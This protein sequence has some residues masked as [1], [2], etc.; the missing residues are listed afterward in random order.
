MR[1]VLSYP[2]YTYD[3]RDSGASDKGLE[4]GVMTIVHI[5]MYSIFSVDLQTAQFI[6]TSAVHSRESN[7][8]LHSLHPD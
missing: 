2:I 1:T 8:C 5:Y 4:I 6:L 3:E 7:Q